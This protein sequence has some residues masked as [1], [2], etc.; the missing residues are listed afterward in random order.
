MKT[1]KIRS[2]IFF[3]HRYVGLFVGVLI[4]IVGLTGSLL[5]FHSELESAL[6]TQRFGN[7][8]PEGQPVGI[9]KIFATVQA[10]AQQSG[11]RIGGIVSPKSTDAPYQARLWDREDRLTQLFVNPYTG[12]VMGKAQ[13]QTNVFQIVLRL[14]YQLMAGDIGTKLVGFVALLLLILSLTG[15]VLWPGWRKLSSGF[16]IKWNAHIKRL[17]F[18]V[19]KVAGIIAAV[20]LTL[21]AFTGLCWNFYDV[22]EPLIYAATFTPQQPEP[23]SQPVQGKGMMNLSMILQLTETALPGGKV[24]WINIPDSATAPFTIYKQLPGATGEFDNSVYL[25]QFS[26]KVL[27]V[28][29]SEE[30]LL[31]DRVLATFTPLHYGTFGGLPT[32]ILYVFVGLAP[33]I[34]LVTGFVMWWH[35]KKTVME[36]LEEGV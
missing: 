10:E 14:H 28:N 32:R 25:D 16:K 21:T 27:R 15:I 6:V 31:G 30:M 9:E 7:V 17:N 20:F 34:L 12:A 2:L 24:T 5:V 1:Q 3:V 18:D 26:G 4:A 11:L 13:E 29:K 23:E 33:T 19:H 35:R 8:T 22:A 36:S